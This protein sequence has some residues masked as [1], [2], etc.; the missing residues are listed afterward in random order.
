MAMESLC[1]RLREPHVGHPYRLGRDSVPMCRCPGWPA[2]D[3]AAGR[4]A[5]IIE[6]AVLDG[7]HGDASG[8]DD[9]VAVAVAELVAAGLLAAS[10]EVRL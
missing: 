3:T 1:E 2:P 6:G 8:L 7:L 5:V 4:A 9:G 10:P